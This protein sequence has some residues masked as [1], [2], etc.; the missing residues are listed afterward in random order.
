MAGRGIEETTC[1]EE[2]AVIKNEK[3]KALFHEYERKAALLAF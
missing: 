1:L 3:L 2:G